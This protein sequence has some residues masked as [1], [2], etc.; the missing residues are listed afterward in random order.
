MC[1]QNQI[2]CV[3]TIVTWATALQGAAAQITSAAAIRRPRTRAAA[4]G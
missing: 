4:R 3:S 2:G 1:H